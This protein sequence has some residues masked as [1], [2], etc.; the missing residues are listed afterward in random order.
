MS[1]MHTRNTLVWCIVLECPLDV[2]VGFYFVALFSSHQL[3]ASTVAALVV[4]FFLECIHIEKLFDA[5][6]EV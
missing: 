2:T 6:W 1:L 5:F 4:V 3:K